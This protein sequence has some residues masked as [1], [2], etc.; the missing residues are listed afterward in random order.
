MSEDIIPAERISRSIFLLRGQKVIPD[1]D[2]ASLYGVET[3]VLNQ[4]VKRN[5]DRFPADFAFHPH[6]GGVREDITN[7]RILIQRKAFK[8][9]HCDLETRAKH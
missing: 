1:R 3:R 9:T 2:L 8:I 7:C 6:P 4:A 5:S